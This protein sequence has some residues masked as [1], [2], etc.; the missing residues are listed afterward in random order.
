MHLTRS[1]LSVITFGNGA[2]RILF[3]VWNFAHLE[4]SCAAGITPPTTPALQRLQLL[5]YPVSPIPKS[6]VYSS[7][8]ARDRIRKPTVKISQEERRIARNPMF[9]LHREGEEKV[10][11]INNAKFDG[12]QTHK[13]AIGSKW[14]ASTRLLFRR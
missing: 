13:G 7:T 11:K 12:E 3:D 6:V 9:G 4:L 5:V 14:N 8:S 2:C 10:N 1:V